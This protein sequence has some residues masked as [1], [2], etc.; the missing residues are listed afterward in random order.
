M[1]KK[2]LVVEDVNSWQVFYREALGNCGLDVFVTGK[3]KEAVHM[4]RN[5][6]IAVIV[7]D[8]ILGWDENLP[9]GTTENLVR[10]IRAWGFTG[11]ILAASSSRTIN[12]VLLQA[13]C[14]ESA[15]KGWEAARRVLGHLV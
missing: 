14:D 10:E 2:I 15:E 12:K 7:M 5:L 11:W 8:G 13:G 4:V 6:D 3:S 9:D 1:R